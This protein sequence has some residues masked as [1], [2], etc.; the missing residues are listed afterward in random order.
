MNQCTERITIIRSFLFK[1]TMTIS[2]IWMQTHVYVCIFLMWTSNSANIII[3]VYVR[4]TFKWNVDCCWCMHCI[5][6]MWGN[7]FADYRHDVW[8]V[9]IYKKL[10]LFWAWK[11]G[12]LRLVSKHLV[13][14][15]RIID[16]CVVVVNFR[17]MHTQQ[18]TWT[19]PPPLERRGGNQ[20]AQGWQDEDLF[21]DT[22]SHA[23]VIPSETLQGGAAV[24]GE[25]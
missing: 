4:F 19:E 8:Q 25:G 7:R 12:L 22:A 2:R 5:L 24:A 21:D 15:M 16:N 20:G 10:P 23:P 14:I 17:M 3:C 9:H 13:W 11:V 6:M 1:F 18:G